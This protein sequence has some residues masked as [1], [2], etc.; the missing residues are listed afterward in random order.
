MS[1]TEEQNRSGNNRTVNYTT[2]RSHAVW[3]YFILYTHSHLT[4]WRFIDFLI[5]VRQSSI[6]NELQ[7][8][9]FYIFKFTVSM[10]IVT[11][12]KKSNKHL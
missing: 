4:M 9:I 7:F 12:W 10:L 8:G 3:I 5:E 2:K 11:Y 1:Y 6:E